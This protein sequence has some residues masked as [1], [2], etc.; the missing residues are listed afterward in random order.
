MEST[1]SHISSLKLDTVAGDAGPD[2]IVAVF[3]NENE[4]TDEPF[5]P[6]LA[7]PSPYIKIRSDKMFRQNICRRELTLERDTNFNYNAKKKKE[8]KEERIYINSLP[9]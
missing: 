7:P 5:H 2:S 6:S 8:E 1:G 3:R 4:F 9:C